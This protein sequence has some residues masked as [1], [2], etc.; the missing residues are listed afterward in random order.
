[1]SP[2][3]APTCSRT[4]R[5]RP[6]RRSY[7]GT[8]SLGIKHSAQKGRAGFSGAKHHQRKQSEPLSQ[9]VL[10]S[11][12]NQSSFAGKTAG[13]SEF[14]RAL[15]HTID[16]LADS[17]K[18]E[19]V[20]ATEGSQRGGQQKS[21]KA[22]VI[23]T[24]KLNKNPLSHKRQKSKGSRDGTGQRL[25]VS[26]TD[27]MVEQLLEEN[28]A[29]KLQVW[30]KSKECEQLRAELDRREAEVAALSEKV[31]G[32]QRRASKQAVYKTASESQQAKA[33]PKG[34]A[35]EQLSRKK[36]PEARQSQPSIFLNNLNFDRGERVGVSTRKLRIPN[37]V[38]KN[39]LAKNHEELPAPT[40]HAVL[41]LPFQTQAAEQTALI[42]PGSFTKRLL[43]SCEALGKS[44]RSSQNKFTS[45]GLISP[46]PVPPSPTRPTSSLRAATA[47][48]LG[49]SAK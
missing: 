23:Q 41:K 13:N 26:K 40:P 11:S 6:V 31:F 29:L 19:K 5:P 34:L 28:S 36:T 32:L 9:Q 27:V 1:M 22:S 44:R 21:L 16:Q 30:R 39:F 45:F 3:K 48:T 37:S 2:A 25:G 8:P 4:C 15:S 20:R 42:R 33:T 47:R 35:R 14:L 43:Q 18:R 10:Q 7:R 17:H 24:A 46:H 12:N 38:F 49:E